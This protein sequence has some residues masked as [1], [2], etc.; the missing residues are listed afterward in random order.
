[1]SPGWRPRR[2]PEGASNIFLGISHLRRLWRGMGSLCAGPVLFCESLRGRISMNI[3]LR[4]KLL[5]V[6]IAALLAASPVLAQDTSSTISGR[7]LDASGQPV[8]GATVQIV[9]EP[10]GTTKTTVTDA[11]GRYTAQGLRVGGP[12]DVKV[13]KDGAQTEQDNVFLQL[14]QDTAINLTI[15]SAAAGAQNL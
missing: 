13:S 7:V 5:P 2:P 3:A 4:N 10:T 6:A 1:M 12:F 15:G 14:A 11:S 8:A 9:H